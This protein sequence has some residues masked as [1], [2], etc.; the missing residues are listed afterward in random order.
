M[1]LLTEIRE[2][3]KVVAG[4]PLTR[5]AINPDDLL[6]AKGT[7]AAQ[8]Y[9]VDEVQAVYRAQGVKLHDKHIELI[10]RQMFKYTEILEDTGDSDFLEGQ[11]IERWDVEVENE[12]LQMAGLTPAST[13][14]KLMGIT[15]SALSTR[16]WLSA[17][18][19]QHTTHV[20]TEASIAGKVD[21]LIGLKENVILGKLIPAG[22]G[23]AE[24]KGM[25]VMDEKLRE[26][27]LEGNAR[28]TSLAASGN[29]P[30]VVPAGD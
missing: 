7:E 11:V 24:V 16:S 14:P 25:Q 21:D 28:A 17:A 22:T 9:L 29:A 1:R 3:T 13:T 5:G 19:F 15:K 10:V 18:S 26:K 12:R 4:Q 2:G 23:L 6:V 30:A 20:L 27:I 8:R